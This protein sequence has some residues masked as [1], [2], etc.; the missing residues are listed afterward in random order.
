MV[1]TS[2][3]QY[4]KDIIS[5]RDWGKYHETPEYYNAYSVKT[6]HYIDVD[7]I[8]YDYRYSYSHLGYNLKPGEMNWLNTWNP[9]Q[10]TAD[11]S[12]LV[13]SQDILHLRVKES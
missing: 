10:S 9:G 2:N 13:I 12:L 3:E 4:A 7:G 8:P 5:L 6:T 1:L 11:Y